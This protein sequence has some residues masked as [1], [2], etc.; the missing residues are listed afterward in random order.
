MRI[1]NVNTTDVVCD[2]YGV[3]H[4]IVQLGPAK[5]GTLWTSQSAWSTPTRAGYLPTTQRDQKL[6]GF[7]SHGTGHLAVSCE[8]LDDADILTDLTIPDFAT[9]HPSEYVAAAERL[10]KRI[11]QFNDTDD[12]DMGLQMC[13]A[14]TRMLMDV[15]TYKAKREAKNKKFDDDRRQHEADMAAYQ[16]LFDQ[17]APMLA[18]A[19]MDDWRIEADA[20]WNPTMQ[21][22]GD[23]E[24][25][26][27]LRVL[28]TLSEKFKERN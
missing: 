7:G 3:P 19:G 28:I 5:G 4:R 13:I 14:D 27:P 18:D 2:K 15:A 22:R 12:G 11:E 26:V 25:R 24:I 10:A 21:S 17:V 20:R 1:T 9:I 6:Y 8:R 16:E 23:A